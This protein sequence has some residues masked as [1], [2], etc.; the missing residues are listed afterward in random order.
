MLDSDL[1][2]L[3]D[4]ETKHLNRAVKRNMLRFPEDFM[5]QLT[6][7]ELKEIQKIKN[8][9][10]SYGGARKVPFAFTENGI[11]ML[12][13]VLNSDRAIVINISIIRIFMKLR[14]FLMLEKGLGERIDKLETG[15][16][17]VFK[18][19]FERLDSIEEVIDTKLP[20]TKRKIGLKNQ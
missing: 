16:N 1:A 12:S 6:N 17:Q 14:S 2:E 10:E 18:A 11:A 9:G 19:V 15:N 7:H 3:Y 20:T 8:L 5:F 13:S 4:V